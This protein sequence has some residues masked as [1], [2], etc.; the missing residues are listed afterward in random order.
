MGLLAEVAGP[1]GDFVSKSS[2]LVL[3]AS[4]FASFIV[5]AVVL[6]VLKQLLIKNP[7]EPP[8]VFHWFPVLGST[9]TYGIDPFKFFF[10]NQK[11]VGGASWLADRVLNGCSTATCSRSS[12]SVAR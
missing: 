3:V 4:G 12:S 1:L 10:A 11:K 9:I 5:L 2:L 8:L 6:N 7:N